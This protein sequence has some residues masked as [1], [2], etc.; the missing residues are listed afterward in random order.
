MSNVLDK[1]ITVQYV[2]PPAP[3]KKRGTIKTTAGETFGV[4]PDMIG[5][6]QVG[7][8]YDIEIEGKPFN[9][10]T[11]YNV[12]DVRPVT[13]PVAVATDGKTSPSSPPSYNPYRE[14]SPKDGERMFV[15]ATLVA[16]IQA[17]EVKN[18]KRQL[19]ETTNMLR[20]LWGAAFGES[21]TFTASEAER[22]RARA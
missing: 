19:W 6:F 11:L 12:T 10:T 15:C 21:N 2:N 5:S 13:K 4:W 16:L 20:G 3:G 7:N 18:D 9:G 8:S 22:G 17:G 14:T 1:T